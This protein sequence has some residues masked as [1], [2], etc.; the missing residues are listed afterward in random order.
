MFSHLVK[1]DG[2]WLRQWGSIHICEV[3]LQLGP[4]LFHVL[5]KRFIHVVMAGIAAPISGT[6]KVGFERLQ[7][8]HS[9]NKFLPSYLFIIS[10]HFFP[11]LFDKE[12]VGLYQFFV[13]RQHLVIA[14][15]LT[16]LLVVDL[17]EAF[18]DAVM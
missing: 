8:D 10:L 3:S 6:R 2:E 14:F 7:E 15:M 9:G 13:S 18:I 17:M 1:E 11:L 4:V 5:C 16:P 12:P